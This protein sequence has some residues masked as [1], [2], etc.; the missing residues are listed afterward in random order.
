MEVDGSFVRIIDVVEVVFQAADQIRQAGG[1]A[2]AQRFP[3]LE[4]EEQ[5]RKNSDGGDGIEVAS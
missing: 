4:W 3:R 1:N 2:P 5:G